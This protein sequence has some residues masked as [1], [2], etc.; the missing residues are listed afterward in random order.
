MEGLCRFLGSRA[1]LVCAGLACGV[2]GQAQGLLYDL[3][4]DGQYD[5][6]GVSVAP[7]GDVDNDGYPDFVVGASEDFNPFVA[8]PGYARVYSG[9][10]GTTLHTFVGA[11][12]TSKFG[13]AV[14]GVGDIDQ[15][16]YDDIIVGAPEDNTSGPAAGLARVFSGQSGAVL[17]T[18]LGAYGGDNCGSSVAGIGDVNGDSIP[19]FAVGSRGS[20]LNGPSSGVVHIHSGLS[21]LVLHQ[22]P[23]AAASHRLGSAM[24]DVGDVDGDGVGDLVVGSFFGGVSLFS[25]VDGSVIHAIPS[26]SSDDI[27]GWSVAGL[28]DVTGDGVPDFFVGA[29]QDSVFQLGPGYAQVFD[30][31]TG[32]LIRTIAGTVNGE[33]FGY[34]VSSAGDFD[35]DGITDLLVGAD[36][37]TTSARGYATVYSGFDGSP[38]HTF[39]GEADNAH[40]GFSVAFLGDLN[41][42]QKPE[43][44]VGQPGDS[45]TGLSSGSVQVFVGEVAGC[46]SIANYCTSLPNSSGGAAVI[47]F[48]GT[49][50]IAANDLILLVTGAAPGQP[51]L[52]YYGAAPLQVPFGNGI[53]CIGGRVFRLPVVFTDLSGTVAWA[54]DNT[55]PPGSE[56]Q[57]TAGSTWYFQNWFRDPAGGGAQVN[58]SDGL[59]VPFC[60]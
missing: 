34:S 56:G 53:R 8:G 42:D 13:H 59:R 30:G 25:G 18:I 20:D 31:A 35:G 37:K 19:D 21:G 48:I 43:V 49:N 26:P 33:R 52:F 9:I 54:L 55:A 36:Q 45:N 57:V 46:G 4:G 1:L 6:L 32:G 51:S 11:G 40:F 2:T 17:H 41:G 29:T 24:D 28:G 22:I 58:T 60:P 7:A 16:G 47:S 44:A 14:A 15:D 12:V 3:D 5:R 39:Q 10:D 50:S 23:G 38:M 27:F